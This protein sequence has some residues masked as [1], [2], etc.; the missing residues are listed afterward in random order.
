VGQQQYLAVPVWQLL[1]SEEADLNKI[2]I[3]GK[4]CVYRLAAVVA[5][6]L[7]LLVRVRTTVAS[8]FAWGS[9]HSGFL[10]AK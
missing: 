6:A 7:A 4:P 1:S 3:N 10:W 8:Q 2:D 5:S 9:G